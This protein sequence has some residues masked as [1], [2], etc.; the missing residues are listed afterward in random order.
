MLEKIDQIL[1]NR[2]YWNH[3]F[4]INIGDIKSII[5]FVIIAVMLPSINTTVGIFNFLFALM[6]LLAI[7][8]LPALIF[9]T[10][11]EIKR[12]A[13]FSIDTK[14]SI[15]IAL[16]KIK[17]AKFLIPKNFLDDVMIFQYSH[18]VNS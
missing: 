13:S 17:A 4:S 8:C 11:N 5:M 9:M 1:E 18:K 15:L 12:S 2:V 10:I 6:T 16:K 7:L 14:T 3:P